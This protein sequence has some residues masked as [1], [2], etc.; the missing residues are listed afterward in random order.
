MIWTQFFAEKAFYWKWTSYATYICCTFFTYIC[1][2]FFTYICCTFSTYICCTFI[3]YMR[4]TFFTYI[5]CT[6]STY[7]CCTFLL[8]YAVHFFLYML[9]FFTGKSNK[10]EYNEVKNVYSFSPLNIHGKPILELC[11]ICHRACTF[12][13]FNA[14]RKFPCKFYAIRSNK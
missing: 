12:M 3:T 13:H 7:I 11:C 9:Y 5:R 10:R 8:I 4:C 2:T 1:C 14:L 6:F